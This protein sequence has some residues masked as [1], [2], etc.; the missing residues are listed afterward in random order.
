MN[1]TTFSLTPWT[2]DHTATLEAWGHD[3]QSLLQAGLDAALTLMVGED[4]APGQES[5]PV[6]PLRGEGDT[7]AALVADLLDDLLVQ[8]ETHGPMQ[9]AALDGVLRRD[10]D[11]F[12]AWGYLMPRVGEAS[13]AHYERAG[14]VEVLRETSDE[15]RV[16]ATLRRLS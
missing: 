9:G 16:R 6:V 13:R 4:A 7:V 2:P 1:S 15:I 8:I 5:T 10:R 14:E 11:G 3:R 12:V